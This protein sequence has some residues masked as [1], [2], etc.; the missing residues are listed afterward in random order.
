MPDP[1]ALSGGM[2]LQ[3]G[4]VGTASGLNMKQCY[5]FNIYERNTEREQRIP[6]K[7]G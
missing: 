7:G 4:V 3:Y 5:N 2:Q 6:A 1:A